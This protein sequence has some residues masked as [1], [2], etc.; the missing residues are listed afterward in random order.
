[1]K[2]KEVSVKDKVYNFPTKNKE[3]FVQSEIDELLKGFPAIDIEKF[4][5][6]L[7]VITVQIINNETVIFH[8]DI[9]KAIYCGLEKR[10]LKGYE[11]D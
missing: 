2:N 6:A 8:D 7:G 5:N 11:F 1:M 9:K 3:G 10:E 4:N